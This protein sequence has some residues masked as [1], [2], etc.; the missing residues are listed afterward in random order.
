MICWWMFLS[1]FQTLDPPSGANPSASAGIPSSPLLAS[2]A[3]WFLTS[4]LFPPANPLYYFPQI[5]TN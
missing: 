5:A 3:V 4:G 2:L 1:A